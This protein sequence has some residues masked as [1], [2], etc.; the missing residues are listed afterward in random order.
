[1]YPEEKYGAECPV[2]RPTLEEFRDFAGFIAR[3]EPICGRAGVCRVVPPAGWFAHPTGY[4]GLD[5]L[6][7]HT[8][9]QQ[10]V[11]GRA[12]VYS[13]ALVEKQTL[14]LRDFRAAALRR[15]ELCANAAEAPPLP[16]AAAEEA[17]QDAIE[18]RFWRGLN[19]TM[20]PA[21]YGADSVG[22]L[23][24]G[25]DASGWNVDRLDTIL[26][27]HADVDVAGVSSSML[28]VGMWQALFAWHVED[29][30]LF[31]INYIHF[32]RPKSWWFVPPEW[33]ARFESVM[34]SY[35]PE[36]AAR[37]REY[38]RHKTS[39]ISPTRLRKHGIPY[40]RVTQRAGE[41]VLTFPYAYHAGFNQGF[42]LAESANFASPT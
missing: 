30:N 12:G 14:P 24:G 15:D 19:V 4:A 33:G 40:T 2:F 25:D 42:N 32:G 26:R 23:F 36:E 16:D 1:M 37:C 22:S 39:L 27:R 31:S 10:V 34:A 3:I 11:S 5:E 17:A 9:A 38:L 18:R 35:F 7:V 41:F 6:T 13:V 29:M 20:E 28:Y 21:Q 8:P